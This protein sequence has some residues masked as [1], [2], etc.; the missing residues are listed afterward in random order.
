[1]KKRF[2]ML[3]GSLCLVAN[4]QNQR[5]EQKQLQTAHDSVKRIIADKFPRTR[6]F[7]A[8]YRVYAPS[9]FDSELDKRAYVKGRITDHQQWKFATNLTLVQKQRWNITA[10]VDYRYES[11]N[12]T[13]VELLSTDIGPFSKNEGYHYIGASVGGMYYASLFGKPIIY[14]AAV[15]VDGSH[16]DVERIKGTLGATLLLKRTQRTV[17]GLGFVVLI[18]PASPVPAAPVFTV[19]HKFLNSDW[20]LD[21][22]LPQRLLFKHPIASNGRISIGTELSG[23]GFYMYSDNPGY[24]DVYDFRQLE[25]R[26]G[27]TYEHCIAPGFV[28]YAKT[29]LANMFNM[30]VSERGKNTNKYLLSANQNATGYVSFGLSYNLPSKK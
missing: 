18:D 14:A 20:S 16:K 13:D 6:T 9:D 2:S 11:F 12:V 15:T 5:Q 8:Q 1:M 10:N 24:A 7:D 29:G 30:R 27:L 23:D 3:M 19:D 26:S 22:I 28:A 25:L 4:A 21:L 17:I